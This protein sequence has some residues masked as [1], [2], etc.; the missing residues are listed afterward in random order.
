MKGEMGKFAVIGEIY[1]HFTEKNKENL[2]R[3]AENLLKVQKKDEEIV[4]NVTPMVTEVE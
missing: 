3:I 1:T 2:M 4:A